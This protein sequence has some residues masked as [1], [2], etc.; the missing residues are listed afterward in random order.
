MKLKVMD[1]SGKQTSRT[2]D[3]PD[4]IF[5]IEPNDHLIWLDVRA[6]RANGP[7]AVIRGA[8]YGRRGTGGFSAL[9]SW[10]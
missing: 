5:N 1:T 10:A 6:I 7:L 2:V 3:L 4:S 8:W 9:Q